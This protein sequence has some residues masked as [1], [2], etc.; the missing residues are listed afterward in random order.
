MQDVDRTLHVEFGLV[1]ASETLLVEVL[2]DRRRTHRVTAL[3]PVRAKDRLE[4]AVQHRLG[5]AG[6]RQ[7]GQ[8]SLQRLHVGRDEAAEGLHDA[9]DDLVGIGQN[10]AEAGKQAGELVLADQHQ[11][12]NVERTPQLDQPVVFRRA[13]RRL[14][15]GERTPARDR[16]HRPG[17]RFVPAP[18]EKPAAARD[19][20]CHPENP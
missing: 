18:A 1:D 16:W 7:S 5:V 12:G 14:I 6:R 11:G 2:G 3:A 10:I 8:N 19:S 9:L 13:H 4:Q 17:W 15:H 20:A